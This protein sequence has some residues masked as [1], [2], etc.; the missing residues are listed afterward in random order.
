MAPR[1]PNPATPARRQAAE[2]N[3]ASP[4]ERRQVTALCYDLV[5]STDLMRRL[6]LEDYQDL[7]V[8]FHRAAAEA[9]TRQQG[10]IGDV[11]GDGGMAIFASPTDPKDTASLAIEAGLVH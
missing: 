8:A 6:D 9:V 5:Q 1:Q 2:A 3:P 7:M 10:I 11:Y 4:G